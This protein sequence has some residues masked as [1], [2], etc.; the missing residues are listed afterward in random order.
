MTNLQSR[1][2]ILKTKNR[3]FICLR[4]GH[5]A[6]NCRSSINCYHCKGKH[7][8]A[9]CNTKF[10][11]PEQNFQK[12]ETLHSNSNVSVN[13]CASVLL[14]T[15]YSKVKNNVNNS[16]QSAR[17]LFDSGSQLSYITP[18]LRNQLKLKT[19]D[20]RDIFIEAFGFQTTTKKH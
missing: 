8:L 4:P 15:A 5:I 18:A 11:E 14:Q 17:I 6:K 3:C 13:S 19:I 9:V 12:K 20:R 2:D 1:K 7:H 10:S 16:S